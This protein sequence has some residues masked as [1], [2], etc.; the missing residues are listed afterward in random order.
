MV[1]LTSTGFTNPKVYKRIIQ[2]TIKK[3]QSA[4]IITTAAIPLKENNPLAIRNYNFLS[5][6]GIKK[7]DYMDV[8]FD[9]PKE[10]FNYDLVF[11]LGGNSRHLLY[12]VKQSGADKILLEIAKKKRTIVGASAGAMLLSSGN[13]YTKDFNDILGINEDICDPLDLQGLNITDHILFPHYDMFSEKVTDLESKLVAIESKYNST[14]TRLKNM[15]F[16]YIDNA[17]VLNTVIE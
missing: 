9:D 3:I 15:D 16:I 14:I 13:K 8:E 6:K 10:L 12:H 4:C 7:V 1:F 5:G 17:G 11:I 2:N